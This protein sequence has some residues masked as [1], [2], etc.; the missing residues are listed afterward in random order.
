[1]KILD[2]GISKFQ[3]LCGDGMK[4]TRTGAVMGTPYYMSPEQASGSREADA[5]SD[6]YAVGVILYEAV[7]GQVPFD[8]STF[9]ELL[10]KI[11]L[12][13]SPPPQ[14]IVPDLD[15]A[16]ASIDPR[17]AW[18]ATCATAFRAPPNS[19]KRSMRGC[20]PAAA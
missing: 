19:R 13:D 11:V 4:M 6:L 3:P 9:N 16:F 10:F 18:R 14:S 1:M 12:S 7:T 15:P 2:F 8:A 20:R 5:R 17:R